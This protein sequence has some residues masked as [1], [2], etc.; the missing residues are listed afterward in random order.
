MA[1]SGCSAVSPRTSAVAQKADVQAPTS[2]FCRIASAS[3]QR[4]DPALKARFR[5]LLTQSGPRRFPRQCL[6][7][8]DIA[9]VSTAN[10]W[11]DMARKSKVPES[12]K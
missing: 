11:S 5:R 9:A 2:A 10:K 3:G 8:A 1:R 12:A 7:Y 4:A 6:A